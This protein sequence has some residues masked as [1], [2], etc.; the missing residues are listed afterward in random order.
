MC[1]EGYMTRR[2]RTMVPDLF[3]DPF[4]ERSAMAARRD[5]QLLGARFRFES[6]SGRLLRLVDAAFA[7]LP[8]HRL[9]AIIPRLSVKLVL[10]SGRH[11]QS[12][13][14]REPPPLD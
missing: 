7:G 9:A 14:Q 13:S 3:V 11:P 10:G 8:R 1:F 12:S 4:G 2:N 5:L 6:N